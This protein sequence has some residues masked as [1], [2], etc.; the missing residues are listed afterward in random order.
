[1]IVTVARIEYGDFKNNNECLK[2]PKIHWNLFEELL[3][4]LTIFK[5][6]H[7]GDI[8]SAPT[9]KLIQRPLKL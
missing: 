1:M 3:A 4:N 5:A 6:N 7:F 8:L 2:D 9:T